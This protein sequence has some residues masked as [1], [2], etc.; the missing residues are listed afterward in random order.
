MRKSFL[1]SILIPLFSFAQKDPAVLI[2]KYMQQIV[3]LKDFSGVILIAKKDRV[4]YKKAFGWANQEWNVPNTIDTKFRIGSNTK[5]FTAVAILQLVDKGILSLEDKLTRFFPDF[6]KGDSVTVRML[7]NHTSG[8]RNYTGIRNFSNIHTL[9]YARDSVVAFF[10]NQPYEFS[11]G[12]RWAYNNSAFFLLGYIV[13]KLTGQSYGNY[14]DRFILSKSNMQNSGLNNLDSV[15]KYRAS[16]YQK[17]KTG[18]KNAAYISMEFPFSAGAMF[19]TAD[20]LLK[21]NKALYGGKMLSANILQHMITPTIN[22]YGLGLRI[23]SFYNHKR[24]GHSGSI[25]GFESHNVWFPAEDL[26][27]ILL[28]NNES[29]LNAVSEDIETIIFKAPKLVIDTSVLN[30]FAGTYRSSD[31]LKF[32]FTRCGNALCFVD[33]ENLDELQPSSPTSFF[34]GFTRRR[35]FTFIKDQNGKMKLHFLRSG[36][37]ISKLEKTD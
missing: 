14:M 13:E 27:I 36:G 32:T 8:I 37:M 3:R 16:G 34:Y 2:D 35:Y 29:N 17:T 22:N 15:I 23:D 4:I 9:P 1:I 11:P 21:W 5:T 6:P 10:K 7:L 28:T 19:S 31:S 12:T 30:A 24:V 26:S 25:P 33:G 20:D 18:W